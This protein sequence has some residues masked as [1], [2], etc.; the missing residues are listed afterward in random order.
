MS[1]KISANQRT[2]YGKTLAALG[3]EDARICACEA[4]LGK[5]TMSCFFEEA[6][7]DRYFEMGIGEAN[8]TSFAAGLSLTGKIV[9]T[10]SFAMFSG[11]RAFEQIR[12]SVA[13]P[14]CNVKIIGSSAGL[15][16]FGDGASHQTV[17]DIAALR[18]IPNMT[19]LVPCDANE[20]PKM[21]RAAV[22]HD[23]PVYIRICRND[24]PTLTEAEGDYK[25]GEMRVMREG[26]DVAIFACGI[27]V[28]RALDAA[29]ALAEC[30]ISARVI[31]A[32]TLKP[33]DEARACELTRDV[34]G[35][36]TAEEHSVIG[37]LGSAVACALRRQKKP[38]EIVG[39]EDQFGQSA[40]SAEE[41]M[42]FYG[43]TAEHIAEAAKSV[44]A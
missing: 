39:I 30:G 24:T 20:V 3:A 1:G 40:Q 43:L 21:V 33:F 17:E 7:P 27:M 25:I 15:S 13:L 41:L 42:Q 11:L 44:L 38:L 22:K 9:F 5:S 35:V 23:G 12:Q 31:N 26:T 10:H 19:V 28:T 4:D 14:Y 16:D 32:G 8:M 29:E 34:R 37:G 2:A 6:F 18:A 36:V